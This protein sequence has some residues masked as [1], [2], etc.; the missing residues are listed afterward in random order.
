MGIS[1]ATFEPLS[2]PGFLKDAALC[3]AVY[4]AGYAAM[5][6]FSKTMEPKRKA[7]LLTLMCSLGM[8]LGSVPYVWRLATQHGFVTAPFVY[9]DDRL[10]LLVMAWFMCFLV[11][12]LAVGVLQYP[13]EI[14]FLTGYFHHTLYMAMCVW[15]VVN[16][17]T[18]SAVA[19]MI[20]EIPTFILALGRVHKACRSDAGFGLTFLLTR[21]L[22]LGY[23]IYRLMQDRERIVIW[24]VCVPAMVLHLLWF[25]GFIQ[26][27]KRLYTPRSND[28]GATAAGGASAA[29]ATATKASDKKS[30]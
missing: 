23:Y 3:T 24:P 18:I 26:Q 6:G 2:E 11:L 21:I 30:E 19:T 13:R 1:L 4:L 20:M 7:W 5:G 8:S 25:K 14:G 10:S 9:A 16:A 17:I 29:E 22:Y 12:D 28:A 27:Q 15:A